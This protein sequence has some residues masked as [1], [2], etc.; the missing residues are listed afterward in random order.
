MR[1]IIGLAT[2][3]CLLTSCVSTKNYRDTKT[4]MLQLKYGYDQ[5][6]SQVEAIKARNA[7]LEEEYAKLQAK[8]DANDNDSQAAELREMLAERDQILQEIRSQL[9][10]AIGHLEGKGMTLTQKNGKIYVQMEEKLLYQS[11][12][13]NITKEGKS[14][15]RNIGSVLVKTPRVDIIIEGHTDNK[16]L[17]KRKDAQIVDNWDLSCKRATEVVRV[18]ASTQGIDPERITASGRGQ[19]MPLGLNS[20]DSGRAL[21]RRTEIIITP[22]MD[23]L[24]EL[25]K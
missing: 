20:T 4:E 11:G 2:V 10:G 5:M 25:L 22:Q 21:N 24:I 1:K 15:I 3:L 7:T 14:A 9:T 18:L 23:K 8:L 12:K 19:Y 6:A 17:L 16:G 13:Y